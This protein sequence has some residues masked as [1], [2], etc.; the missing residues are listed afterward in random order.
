MGA[1]LAATRSVHYAA[2]LILEGATMFR[3]LVAEPAFGGAV[4]NALLTQRT[5]LNRTM[6]LAWVA[7]VLSGAAWVFIL[8]VEI[9]GASP[10]NALREGI[11]WSLLTQTQ[12]GEVWQLRTVGFLLLLM[13]PFAGREAAAFRW[14]GLAIVLVLALAGSLAWSGHGAATPGALGDLHLFADILHLIA[15]GLWLGGLPPFA[16]LLWLVRREPDITTAAVAT[17]RFSS[18]ALISVL[19][20]LATGIVNTLVLV[21][22]AAALLGTVYGQLLLAKIGLFLL[23]LVFAA[24]NRFLLTPQIGRSSTPGQ[25]AAGRIAIHSMFEFA[26]GM[27]IL[28]IVAVLGTFPPPGH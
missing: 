20:L 25:R 21:G 19:V 8:S 18:I 14:Q 17:R 28:A 22:S 13:L 7:A 12:F 23:M 2:T 3:F 6:A 15:A 27:A 9:A 11:D 16:V 1:A 24:V 10:L 4:H 26:L 5:I